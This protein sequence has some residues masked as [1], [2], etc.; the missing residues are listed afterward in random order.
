M[1]E[2]CLFSTAA[3]CSLTGRL[4]GCVNNLSGKFL[5]HPVLEAPI[6]KVLGVKQEGIQARLV[7]DSKER[8]CKSREKKESHRERTS[9]VLAT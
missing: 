9:P 2:R 7:S 1:Q 8:K 4:R 5:N 3:S 6:Y